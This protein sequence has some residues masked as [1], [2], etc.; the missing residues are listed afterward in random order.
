MNLMLLRVR[1]GF[2]TFTVHPV[3]SLSNKGVQRIQE[4]A[5]K[6]F[7]SKPRDKTLIVAGHSLWMKNFFNI[8]LPTVSSDLVQMARTKKIKNGGLVGFM[9]E[10]YESTGGNVFYRID[11]ESIVQIWKGFE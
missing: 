4:F 5:I 8:Y 6:A 7:T 11:P 1:R 10:K 9:L 2:C 3:K